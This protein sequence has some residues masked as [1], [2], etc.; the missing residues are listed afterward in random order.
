MNQYSVYLSIHTT[1]FSRLEEQNRGLNYLKMVFKNL[2]EKFGH[3]K[4]CLFVLSRT[5]YPR[6]LFLFSH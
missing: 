6:N 2:E 4:E 1:T 5:Y 3:Q